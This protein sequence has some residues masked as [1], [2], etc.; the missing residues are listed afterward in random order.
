MTTRRVAAID[1]APGTAQRN[2]HRLLGW[3]TR[4]SGLAKARSTRSPALDLEKPHRACA[5]LSQVSDTWKSETY[6]QGSGSTRITEIC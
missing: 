6:E 4:R 3:R 5:E 1:N 2:H